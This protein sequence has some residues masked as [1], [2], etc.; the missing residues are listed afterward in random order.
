MTRKQFEKLVSEAVSALPD[1]FLAHLGNVD[2]VVEEFPGPDII[3]IEQLESPYDLL[4]YYEGVPLTER[5][6]S[7][8]PMIPDRITIFQ[9]PIESICNTRAE[10]M[11]EIQKTVVH[12]VAHFF[13]LDEDRISELG[14]E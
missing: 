13:G 11:E 12:E 4:G 10:L 5:H 14:W 3:E 9:A 1:E 8:E 2:I 6:S 7:S